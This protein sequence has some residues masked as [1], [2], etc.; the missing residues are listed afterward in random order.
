MECRSTGQCA[1]QSDS[2]FLLLMGDFQ[3]KLI[4]QKLKYNWLGTF[5]FEFN[6]SCCIIFGFDG[7]IHKCG[8]AKV[9]EG[10]IVTH[11]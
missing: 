1:R 11:E 3:R 6:K 8:A 7:L 4:K 10:S 5:N 2:R 9:Q